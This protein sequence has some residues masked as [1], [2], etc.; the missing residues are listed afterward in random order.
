[1][2]ISGN[3]QV[4]ALRMTRVSNWAQEWYGGIMSRETGMDRS[5]ATYMTP[6]N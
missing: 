1:M 6:Y 2:N 4:E 5:I 3:A